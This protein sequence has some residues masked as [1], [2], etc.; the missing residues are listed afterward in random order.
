VAA[1]SDAPRVDD[2]F[3]LMELM[4]VVVLVA[5]LATVI[6]AVIAVI[7]RNAPSAEVQADNSRSYRGLTTWL[8][9]DAASTPPGNFVEDTIPTSP[10]GPGCSGITGPALVQMSWTSDSTGYVAGYRLVAD[11]DGQQ[12]NRYTCSGPVASVPYSDPIV[13]S[14]TNTL[15]SARPVLILDDLSQVVGVRIE[16]TTCGRD[17]EERVDCSV[18]GPL[19]S[20]QASSHNPGPA[21]SL[22]PVPAAP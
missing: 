15:H 17:A 18:Q 5:I 19:V 13:R 7:L 11:G 21:N 22:P 9:R 10:P 6:V 16:M 3:T 14:V 12:I 20:V 1:D 4:V 8:P 2:G